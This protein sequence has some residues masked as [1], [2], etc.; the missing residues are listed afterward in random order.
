MPPVIDKSKCIGCHTC[1]KV[2]SADVYGN[3]KPGVKIPEVRFPSECWACNACVIDCPVGAIK[4]RIPLPE[5][6]VF[7]EP[8]DKN[9]TVAPPDTGPDDKKD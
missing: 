5:M 8:I 2:C 3:Q 6:M 7:M 9:E 1:V 4:L